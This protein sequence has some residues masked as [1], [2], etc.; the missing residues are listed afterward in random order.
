MDWL[1]ILFLFVIL[2]NSLLIHSSIFVSFFHVLRVSIST[3][4]HGF[5]RLFLHFFTSPL[6]S[7]H[8]PNLGF[9]LCWLF[10]FII[11][12]GLYAM[13]TIRSWFHKFFPKN[14]YVSKG[15]QLSFT[16]LW[17]RPLKRYTSKFA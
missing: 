16:R 15:V 1:E 2:L 3:Q 4:Y 5:V 12:S 14:R 9:G 6:P 7:Y 8:I 13:D 10:T 11:S 17:C